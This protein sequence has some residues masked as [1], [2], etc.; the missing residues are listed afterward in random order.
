MKRKILMVAFLAMVIG[1]AAC[2]KQDKSSKTKIE[3]FSSKSENQ[4][5]FQ[6]LVKEFEAENPDIDVVFTSPADA[7]T[8]LRTRLVKDDIPNVIAYGGDMT[9]TE[10]ANVGMLK[11]FSQEKLVSDLSPAYVQMTKDLQNDQEKLYGIPYATNASGVIYNVDLFEKYHL[12]IPKT[13]QEFIALCEFFKK[14]GITPIE[15]T[16]KDAWT[17]QSVFNP[18]AGILS[19]EGFMHERRDGNQLF[20]DEWQPV[21]EKLA[22]IMTYTQK[23]AMGTSYADGVQALAKG[24]AAMLINGTWAIPEV[25]KANES[26]NVKIFALPASDVAEDNFATSGVD[27]MLMIGKETP[28]QAASL[29]FITF[30]TEKNQAQRYSEDQF[31][32]SAVEGVTQEDASLADLSPLIESGKVNDFVDHLLPNGY[33]LGALLSEFAM[34]QTSKP[35]NLETNIKQILIKMD[36][37]YDASYVE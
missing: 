15:G 24:E 5:I 25:M 21:F 11:D 17:L 33:D 28:N 31:A 14:E 37:A 8:V 3:V 6:D 34:N 4:L 2:G 36:E 13:W 12:E 1:L 16:F 20:Q 27:V 35:Q 29:R 22:T 9:Y 32:F 18:L 26:A 19:P 7:G 23:D 10:L 30:L